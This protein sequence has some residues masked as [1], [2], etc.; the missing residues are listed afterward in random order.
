MDIESDLSQGLLGVCGVHLIRLSVSKLR[1]RF[2][3]L[4]E[5]PVEG[6]SKL[7]RIGHNRDMRESLVIKGLANGTD[8]AVHHVRRRNHVSPRFCMGQGHFRQ[9]LESGIVQDLVAFHDATM[10]VAHVFTEADIGYNHYIFGCLLNCSDGPLNDP[11]G[12]IGL[13]C[14]VI[15][16]LRNSEKNNGTNPLI[17]D[18][19]YLFCEGI[20]R[21]LVV[22]GHGGDRVFD[23]LARAY[24]QRLDQVIQSH[25][26]FPDEVSEPLISP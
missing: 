2:G 23:S 6:R 25:M 16:L 12:C 10:S 21:K 9:Q 7:C 15:F 8:P 19:S 4:P 3:C 1:R 26:S 24:K 11:T 17:P 22:I 13:A 18:L 14:L 20:D 5:R